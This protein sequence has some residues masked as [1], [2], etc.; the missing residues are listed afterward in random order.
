MSEFR[1]LLRAALAAL[2]VAI[3]SGCA[4]SRIDWNTRIGTYTFDDAVRELGP[5]DKSAQLTDRSTVADWVTSRGSRL[6]TAYVGG[7]HPY[8]PYGWGGPSYVF[9]D[10]PGPD[11]ILRLTFDPQG[12]LASWDRVYQ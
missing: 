1:T 10:P 9:L 4:S 6:S 12:R 2:V 5:P 3:A 8:G 11:R 7:W